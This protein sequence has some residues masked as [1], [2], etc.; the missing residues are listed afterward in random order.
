MILE[1]YIPAFP[2]HQFIENFVYFKGYNPEHSIDRY[3]PDGY[4]SI[5]FDMTD[6]PKFIYDNNTLKEI[7]SC[8]KV[9]FSGIRENFITIPS[10]RDNEMLVINFHKGKAYPFVE[11][12]MHELTD[13][14]VDGELVLSNEILNLREML[15]ER[16]SVQH[17]FSCVEQFLMKLFSKRL[18]RNVFVDYSVDQIINNPTQLSIHKLSDKVGFS[19]KH[20]IKIFKEHV[21]L[22]PKAFLKIVRFQKAIRD[23]EINR[24]A[25]WTDIALECGYYDQ[26]HFINDFKDFSGFTPTQYLKMQSAFTNYI[27]VG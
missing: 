17:K 12:P 14:V 1:S 15:L 16:Y 20:F 3:L 25:N 21:G 5:V 8:R 11:M 23:I 2:L 10:G 18:T 22:S 24:S 9:W 27:A 13:F 26:A 19:Q 4:T 7:Q 6:H